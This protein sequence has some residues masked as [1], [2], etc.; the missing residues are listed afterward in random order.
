MDS[1]ILNVKT[2]FLLKYASDSSIVKQ[3]QEVMNKIYNENPAWWPYGL[4]VEGHK[5]VYLVKDATTNKVA[6][7]V[8]WQELFEN[9]KHV[10]S[11]SIGILPEFRG[12]GFAKEAVAKIISKKAAQVDIVR[13]YI[14]KENTTSKH[15][16]NSLNIPII[17]DF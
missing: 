5:D 9:G 17:E 11:Y 6:G 14:K 12:K 8:G 4:T 15:L 16:A 3:A 1:N 13:S 10:G 2:K 7:F